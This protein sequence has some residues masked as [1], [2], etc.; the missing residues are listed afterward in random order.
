MDPQTAAAKQAILAAGGDPTP[1]AVRAHTLS[2][3]SQRDT[4]TAKDDS[5][6]TSPDSSLDAPAPAPAPSAT[7][8][9]APGAGPAFP[10]DLAHS[11]GQ[12]A[13]YALG[14]AG[15]PA[16]AVVGAAAGGLLAKAVTG[17]LAPGEVAKTAFAT[18]GGAIA[19][20]AGSMVG[21]ALGG[22]FGGGDQASGGA[23]ATWAQAAAAG[24]SPFPAAALAARRRWSACSG[25]CP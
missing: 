6:V 1:E 15:G 25:K 8:S 7:P 18:I 19:G 3:T 20:K 5:D 24:R 4:G 10:H 12:M 14:S 17:K 2:G 13:G 11:L 22:M 16:G 9:G 23:G 21:S